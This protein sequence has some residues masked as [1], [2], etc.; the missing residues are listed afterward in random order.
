MRRFPISDTWNPV[1][2]NFP[3]LCQFCQVTYQCGF[4]DVFRPQHI[5]CDI[6]SRTPND[7]L[8]TLEQKK[9]PP[10]SPKC[11]SHQGTYCI[12]KHAVLA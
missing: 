9:V 8:N 1:A 12:L 3:I 11:G 5:A 4:Y 6:F 10:C 7:K 2:S